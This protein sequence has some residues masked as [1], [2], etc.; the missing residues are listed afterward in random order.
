MLRAVR[1]VEG[2]SLCR[3]Q[4]AVSRA[5]RRVEGRSPCRGYGATTI[6][7]KL[8]DLYWPNQNECGEEKARDGS[9]SQSSKCRTAAPKDDSWGRTGWRQ[10]HVTQTEHE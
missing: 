6:F 8:A 1:R 3:G 5:D 2:R 10:T 4:V 7:K 9:A